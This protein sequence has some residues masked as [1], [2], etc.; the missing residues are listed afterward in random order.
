MS[1]IVKVFK[2]SVATNDDLP[3]V[4]NT[5]GDV[6][7]VRV[8]GAQ[9]FWEP[10][11]ATGDL[12]D[13]RLVND[14]EQ[15]AGDGTAG[16]LLLNELEVINNV[17]VG[18]DI[19][20]VGTGSSIYINGDEVATQ[21]WVEDQLFGSEGIGGPISPA[22]KDALELEL[23][24]KFSSPDRY[25]E[26]SYTGDQLTNV[27]TWED[28]TKVVKLWNKDLS[29]TGDQLTQTVLTRISDSATVTKDFVYSGDQLTQVTVDFST[30]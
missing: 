22:E 21:P 11:A 3:L 25:K 28:N 17:V 2:G 7:T 27:G 9:Y 4:G 19:N 6:Y 13:W 18:G 1:D 5:R 10:L 20:V 24:Y 29:Y 16:G 12:M 30:V 26:L 15:T 8:T 14:P 23:E